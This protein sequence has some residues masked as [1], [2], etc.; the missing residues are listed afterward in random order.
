MGRHVTR[1]L[2]A[3]GYAV[4]GLDKYKPDNVHHIEEWHETDSH[5]LNFLKQAAE[6]CE[7]AIFLGGYSRPGDR[8][9]S[10]VEAVPEELMHPAQ[11]AEACGDVG[12]KRFIFTSSGGTVYGPVETHPTPETETNT[13]L[14]AYG[15]TK[16]AAE[17]FLRLL[18]AS[19]GIA[20]S[21]LRVSNP[22]GPG[23]LARRGQGFIAA[24]MNAAYKGEMLEIWGD[25]SVVRDF[26][27]VGDVA[28][29][30]A[31][32]C[33]SEN[34]FDLVNVSFGKGA[35]LRQICEGVEAASGRKLNVKYTRGRAADVPISVL[36][37]SRAARV[38]GWQPVTSLA[39]GLAKTARWWESQ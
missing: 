21:V 34:P 6:S 5:D 29:A 39:E 37:N 4:I 17:H 20:T 38:L 10:I 32:A 3:A 22:Y 13:P 12:V 31:A 9:R 25:G 2:A 30:F 18:S 14:N 19:S 35:S 33:K 1:T 24:A 16:L 26:I 23:Q 28:D 7:A 15:V 11:V 36:D 8:V 27:Y